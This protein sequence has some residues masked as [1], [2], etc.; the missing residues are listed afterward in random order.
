MSVREGEPL[1]WSED[2]VGGIRC[3]AGQEQPARADSQHALHRLVD[4]QVSP[5]GTCRRQVGVSRLF[6]LCL[7]VTFSHCRHFELIVDL[8]WFDIHTVL[9][10]CLC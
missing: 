5:L 2:H 10:R 1:L 3:D 4:R 6:R 7:V 9:L 8:R